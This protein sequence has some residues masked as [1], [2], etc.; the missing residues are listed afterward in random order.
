MVGLFC[1][2]HSGNCIQG[3]FP[4]FLTL[5]T[6]IIAPGHQAIIPT[7]TFNCCGNITEWQINV[8]VHMH[9][10]MDYS[11]WYLQHVDFQVWRPSPTVNTTG[12]YSLVGHN[13]FSNV[14]LIGEIATATPP[15]HNQIQVQPGD[16][17]GFYL[18]AD[19]AHV[20]TEPVYSNMMVWFGR[21]ETGENQNSA[22]PHPIARSGGLDSSING[23]PLI[24]VSLC[25]L[26]KNTYNV[27]VW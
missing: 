19:G 18:D 27:H 25:R 8:H 10:Y 6:D 20:N 1:L 15:Q 4:S 24:T 21:V 11:L 2:I 9:M 17:V 16:V 14:T 12:C 5:P 3:T 23:A 13:E 22:C 7:Y 26:P